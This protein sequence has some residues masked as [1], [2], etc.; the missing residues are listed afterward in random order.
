[1][2]YI[3]NFSVNVSISTLN[4]VNFS[5]AI[6]NILEEAGIRPTYLTVEIL[7][8]ENISDY[9]NVALNLNNLI[10]KGIRIFFR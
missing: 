6:E 5:N 1:M 10:Q 2:G 4:Q 7:E 8:D 3:D 9:K